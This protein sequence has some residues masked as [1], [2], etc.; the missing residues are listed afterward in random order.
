M[1]S[2][3]IKE[4][5]IPMLY[6][7]K[8]KRKVSMTKLIDDILRPAVEKMHAVEIDPDPAFAE[9]IKTYAVETKETKPRLKKG[10]YH[11]RQS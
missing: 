4:D 11:G 5:L 7:L 8:V 10:A 2:P 9:S 3:K 6:R 1:Y